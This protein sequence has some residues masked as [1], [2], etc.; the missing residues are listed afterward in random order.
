[1]SFFEPPPPSTERQPP[2]RQPAWVAPPE[3]EIGAA[4][5]LRLL[6][7]TTDKLAVAI[8]DAVAYTTGFALRLAIRFHP[9]AAE[10]DPH[11]LMRQLH[12]GMRGST[13]DGL[14]FG[15]EFADGRK[16]TNLGPRR[17][18]SEEPPEI[19][20]AHH[21]GGGGGNRGWQTGYWIYPLPPPGPMT[22]AMAWSGRDIPEET[23]TIDAAPIIG[24][25]AESIIL[26]EDNRPVRTGG[27]S[28]VAQTGGVQVELP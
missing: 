28:P 16:A 11:E 2:G 6:F 1:V 10:F 19:S 5:P 8:I 15:V 20:L 4:V 3:N 13:A 12:G 27:P 7:A 17:P 21:G 23:H 25:A 9:E 22:L 18:P 14:R 26:W 24:A